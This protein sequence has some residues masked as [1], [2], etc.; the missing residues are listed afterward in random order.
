MVFAK[1]TL[2]FYNLRKTSLFIFVVWPIHEFPLL[3]FSLFKKEDPFRP[4]ISDDKKVNLKKFFT[5]LFEEGSK[6]SRKLALPC[7]PEDE[8]RRISF[9]IF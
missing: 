7:H 6:N 9:L 3:F 4:K 2:T 1:S 5:T 8:V